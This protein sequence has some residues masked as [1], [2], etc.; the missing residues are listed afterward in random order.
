MPR[1]KTPTKTN[2]YGANLGF[3]ATALAGRTAREPDVRTRP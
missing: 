2:G 3:E 1:S